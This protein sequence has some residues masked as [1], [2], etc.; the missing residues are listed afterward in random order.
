ME[1]KAAPAIKDRQII[2]SPAELTKPPIT[3]SQSNPKNNY[4]IVTFQAQF[5]QGTSHTRL[6]ASS[7]TE[8]TARMEAKAASS[9]KDRQ[10][11]L[12]PADLMKPPITV[13]W[14]NPKK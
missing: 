7:L 4:I 1:A 3:A 6:N 5:V 9:I 2:P 14:S 10:I 12:S 11:I 13:N 8:V